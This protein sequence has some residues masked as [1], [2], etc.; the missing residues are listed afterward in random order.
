MRW[1]MLASVSTLALVCAAAAPQ[2]TRRDIGILTCDLA[3]SAETPSGVEA[4]RKPQTRDIVCAFRPSTSGPEETYSGILQSVL[5]EPPPFGRHAMIWIVKGLASTE[6][7]PGLLQQTYAVDLMAPAGHPPA[8]IGESNSSI[9]L[10]PM[11]D[12]QAPA[13]GDK[14]PPGAGNLVVLVALKL[15]STPT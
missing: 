6:N 4:S 13:A 3:E 14:R 5:D 2:E 12:S 10:Q 8:L 9:T 7:S 15:R 1:L 11:T